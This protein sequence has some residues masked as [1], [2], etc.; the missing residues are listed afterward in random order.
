MNEMIKTKIVEH[1]AGNAMYELN[2]ACGEMGNMRDKY[3]PLKAKQEG[4]G[5]D[6]QIVQEHIDEVRRFLDLLL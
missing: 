1:I 5:L 6:F 3:T 4:I 2:I